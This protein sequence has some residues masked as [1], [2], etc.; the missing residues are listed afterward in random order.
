MSGLA[1]LPAVAAEGTPDFG[2]NVKIFDPKTPVA[3]INAYLRSISTES[4]FSAG[5]HAVYFQA[6]AYGSAK[7]QNDPATA[8][9]IVNSEVGYYTSIAGLGNAPTDVKINGALHSEPRQGADGSSD[10]LTN[11]YRALSNVSINP[12]QRPV[13][14]DAERSRPEG[15]AGP[16]T[17][18]WATSQAS[19]LRRVQI[20][21]NLDLNGAYGATLFGAEIADSRITGDVNSGGDR[22][23]GQAQYYTRD[24]QIG[25]WSGGSANLVFSGVKGAPATDLTGRGITAIPSTPVSRPAPFLTLNGSSY[26]VFV[27][28]AGT[29]TS[30]VRWAT[31][32]GAGTRI[33]L[34]QFYIAR[35]SDSAATMNAA[36]SAGK[37]LLLTPGVYR[38]T[39]PLKVTRA[40]TVVMGMGYATLAPTG[41]QAAIEVADVQNVVLSS[42]IVDAGPGSRVVVKVGTGAANGIGDA[43]RPTSLTDIFVRVGGAQAGST[44]TMLEVNQSK[45]ILDNTWLWRADHG[46]G[47]GWTSNTSDH[48]LVVNGTDVTALGL[49]VEHNQKNQTVWNGE[50]G[51]TVFYQSEFPYDPPSQTAWMDGTRE[52]YASYK[53]SPSVRVHSATGTA[54]YSLFTS[55]TFAGAPVHAWT[56]V[57]APAAT[58]VRLRSMTNATIALGGGIRHMVN[59]HGTP[60]DASLPNQVVPGFASSARL[61]EYP[62]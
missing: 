25:S 14:T 11:F 27:P 33:G 43:L 35:P 15:V 17:M 51:A 47:V 5:R 18:R 45:V 48:G 60:V 36:L 39:A 49:F 10:G 31:D 46:A 40:G 8:E 32:A 56:S 50:R 26:S 2:P 44:S 16:R 22:G 9:G 28:D 19:S 57:E 6:G 7:G 61:S 41:A 13:G 21:G 4:E 37:N 59:E 24:S 34:G 23:P 58:S 20:E 3:E 12:I 1:V 52:G 30:G 62:G 29:N 55:S 53:V 38:L 42:L 54:I